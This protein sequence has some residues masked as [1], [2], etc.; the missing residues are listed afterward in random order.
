M[1]KKAFPLQNKGMNRD[2][3][4]SK[5]GESSAYEN[6]NIRILANEKD[7]MLSVTNERG[8]KEIPINFLADDFRSSY[9]KV[10]GWNVLNDHIILFGRSREGT[11]GMASIYDVIYRI[12]YDA[13]QSALAD[14][15]VSELLFKGDL[16][17]KLD[18]PIESVV[19]YESDDIQKIYWVDGLH[20]L[21]FMN[22]MA[23]KDSN[24][25][26]PWQTG[27]V[28][29]DNTYFDSNREVNFGVSVDISKDNAGNT[30]ANG[31]VQYF[32]TYYNKFGQESGY[33]WASSLVYLSPLDSGGAAD[34]YNNNN[35][36]LAISGLDSRFSYFRVYSV[37][38]SSLDGQTVAYLVSE[39]KTPANLSDVVYVVDDAAHLTVEDSSRLLYLGSQPVIPGTLEH[40]DQTLFLGDL[41]LEDKTELSNIES[42]IKSSML[43]SSGMSSAILF[44]YSDDSIADIP[45]IQYIGSEGNY[46]YDSQLQYTSSDILSFKGGEKYRFA[47]RF[48]LKDGSDTEAIWI[49]DAENALYPVMDTLHSCIKRVVA[50]CQIPRVVVDAIKN[51]SLIK[52]VQLMVAEATNADRSVKAQGV[53][54]P[55]M[56]NTWERYQDR[57]FS[58]PSWISRVRG[59]LLPSMH[60]QS[61]HK[62]SISTGEVQCNW[63]KDDEDYA[64]PYYQ[65]KDYNTTPVYNEKYAGADDFSHGLIIIGIKNPVAYK[66][67]CTLIVVKGKNTLPNPPSSQDVREHHFEGSTP[68]D[69]DYGW[70]VYD[71]DAGDKAGW[72]YL[73]VGNNGHSDNTTI[74]YTIEGNTFT[75]EHRRYGDTK[76]T[77]SLLYMD[78]QKKLMDLGLENL[79]PSRSRFIQWCRDSVNND[80]HYYNNQLYNVSGY[81]DYYVGVMRALNEFVGGSA[82]DTPNR[83]VVASDYT[84]SSGQG[85]Q[86]PAFFKKHL[87]FIDEN[88][89]TLDSPEL[90]NGN[91]TYDNAEFNFRIVG[92][93]KM[94]SVMS[95]FTIDATKNTVSGTQYDYESFSGSLPM[96]TNLSGI[97]AWPLWKDYR[98]SAKSSAP[99]EVEDRRPSDYDM[100]DSV[101]RYWIY[102]WNHLGNISDYSEN[103]EYSELKTKTFANLRFSYNTIYFN[104]ASFC[105]YIYGQQLDSVRMYTESGAPL[106]MFPVGKEKRNYD[107]SPQLSLTTPG[108]LKYPLYYSVARNSNTDGVI[109]E[110]NV[111]LYSRDVV[112]LEYTTRSHAFISLHTDP[113]SNGEYSQYVLPRYFDKEDLTYLNNLRDDNTHL[114]GAL[115]PWEE[116]MLDCHNYISYGSGLSFDSVFD[117]TYDSEHHTLYATK[118]ISGSGT[119]ELVNT[120]NAAKDAIDGPIYA[121]IDNG[122]L[123]YLARIDQFRTIQTHTPSDAWIITLNDVDVID[124]DTDSSFYGR[125]ALVKDYLITYPG[126]GYSVIQDTAGELHIGSGLIDTTN[127]YREYHIE[128]PSLSPESNDTDADTLTEED[129]YILIGEIYR[130]FSAN[131]TRYGGISDSAVRNNRFLPAGPIYATE[132]MS[133]IPEYE[134]IYGNQGDTYIQR[135]DSLRIKPYSKDS[136]NRVIDITSVMLETHINLDGRTDLQRGIS[137]LAS[138]D[139]TTFGQI[140]SAYSQT[141]NFIVARDLDEKFDEESYRSSITWSLEKKDMADID[142]WTHVTLGTNLKLDGDKGFCR[143]IRRWKNTLL[144]FQDKG[145]SE[146]LFNSRT[147]LSTEEGV[148]VEIANSGKVDGKRYITNKNGC[149]NKWSIVEGKTGLYFVDNIAKAF[150]KYY[151]DYRSEGV[152]DISTNK[153]FGVW[154]RN[155]NSLNEWSPNNFDNFAC[156]YD[157]EHSDIYITSKVRTDNA[158]TL[159]FNELLETFT[160]FFD[161]SEVG[162]MVNVRD[163]FVSFSRNKLWLQNE[164]LYGNFFGTSYPFWV[165]YRATPDPYGDK[166]WTNVE[167]RADVY[168]MLD[169][170]GDEQYSFEQGG[171]DMESAYQ[172]NVTFDYMKFWNEYQTTAAE[173]DY[174]GTP[175]KKFRVWRMDIPRAT[176]DNTHNKY[177]LN[178][179]R[180]PWINILFK[181]NTA[182]GGDRTLMQLHDAVVT[183]FE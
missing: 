128:Q 8:T 65:Y 161:Y 14:Q 94:N 40:K 182:N 59:S 133:V 120:W 79:I 95:D 58:I 63:W 17:F 131:D 73:E 3:S 75:F 129:Q 132:S 92:A 157:Q 97:I 22:F 162:M 33:V 43:G 155:H 61:L 89:V 74:Y 72:S 91:V 123:R 67:T 183:Y 142:E 143:A 16:G 126:T 1:E 152:Q 171:L 54:N 38:R 71:A 111:D 2:L 85:N 173:A 137:E 147:Q 49:G 104:D 10:I 80:T 107:G 7:T 82:T 78:V 37:F 163:R 179:I 112:Q 138:I 90:E 64:I 130:D 76:K 181:K 159:V 113:E 6:R 98:L 156:F 70:N 174:H 145:L 122:D 69:T 30:R 166:I 15:F 96:R 24:G 149:L 114:S 21:R 41:T 158:P 105:D 36:T 31:T 32:L 53:V 154:F 151:R 125:T 46:P 19:Y 177:G 48:K 140:N 42:L 167:Y 84:V 116:E 118:T 99:E 56:F 88:V 150:C 134:I 165:Q 127:I 100:S 4:I 178:R 83:W 60:F 102:M 35:V 164:G 86:T 110:D 27:A 28:T 57:L 66:Y 144:A 93:A 176:Q 170:N 180:N 160:S 12:T 47:L 103:E 141:N 45:N 135:W 9:F 52:A 68:F 108:T 26:Y 11:G 119:P 18:N 168:Q 51:C 172:P 117:V 39:Q 62:S 136:A 175:V 109:S 101:I 81:P 115:L 25:Y 23:K 13:S 124:Y 169:A 121:L 5:A 146:I 29:Y 20:P 50:V 139:T 87:M 106:Y 34:G 55:T 148:P 44:R 77:R 153:G